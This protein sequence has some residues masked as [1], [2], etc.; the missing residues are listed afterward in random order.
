M[1]IIFLKDVGGAGRAGEVKE[2]VDGY[3]LNFLIPRGLAEQATKEKVA[4]HEKRAAAEAAAKSEVAAKLANAIQSLEGARV[5]IK[6]RATEKGGL[7]KSI[8]AKEIAAALT[9]ERGVHISEED[10]QVKQSIKT[11]GEH[12][13]SLSAA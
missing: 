5:E 8:G 10:V 6:A 13:V 4:A 12:N 1:K 7:Y 3:A 2:G 11:T 9:T